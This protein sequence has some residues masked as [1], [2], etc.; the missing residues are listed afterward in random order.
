MWVRARCAVWRLHWQFS[1][2]KSPEPEPSFRQLCSAPRRGRNQSQRSSPTPDARVAEARIK[3][4]KLEKAL[5]A[6]DG[7]SGVEVEAIKKALVKA[8]AAAHEQPTHGV[9]CRL[10]GASSIAQKNDC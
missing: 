5:D 1:V 7:T 6:L 10:Q 3:V 2:P 9:D 8:K 4:A